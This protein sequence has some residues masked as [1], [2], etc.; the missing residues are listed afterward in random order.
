MNSAI[1]SKGLPRATFADSGEALSVT[2]GT[3][4]DVIAG[5]DLDG[6]WYAYQVALN[7]TKQ[8]GALVRLFADPRVLARLLPAL[9]ALSGDQWWQGIHILDAAMLQALQP[10]PMALAI[11]EAAVP[12]AYARRR[13]DQRGGNIFRLSRLD[14]QSDALHVGMDMNGRVHQGLPPFGAGFVKPSHHPHELRG[15]LRESPAGRA[16]AIRRARLPRD[17]RRGERTVVVAASASSGWRDWIP[18]WRSSDMPLRVL[19]L[20]GLGGGP[21]LPRE[22]RQS[23]NSEEGALSIALIDGCSWS[24]TDELLWLSD[25]VLT[26]EEDIAMR[27]MACGVPVL[28]AAPESRP[29][30][31]GRAAGKVL[32]WQTRAW[33]ASRALWDSMAALCLAWQ[34][35]R[36]CATAWQRF[37]QTWDEACQCGQATAAWLQTVPDLTDLALAMGCE[38]AEAVAEKELNPFA[39]ATVPAIFSELRAC[40]AKR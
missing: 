32:G 21:A 17:T 3:V 4:W 13:R 29:D 11:F 20:D 9:D 35:G 33:S 5:T 15:A 40:T 25:L 26:C 39:S 36:H 14:D 10:A 22:M 6:L 31:T 38:Q 30:P 12:S 1:G 27:A 16:S 18:V 2:H 28:Y 24:L 8:H 34:T 23:R 7:L 37:V 19:V